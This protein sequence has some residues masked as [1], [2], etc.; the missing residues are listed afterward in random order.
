[1]VQNY[2]KIQMK[3]CP[4][5][6]EDL[7]RMKTKRVYYPHTATVMDGGYN[8]QK[9]SAMED[10]LV[11]RT[12]NR[13]FGDVVETKYF[14]VHLQ[15]ERLHHKMLKNSP[16]LFQVIL[17]AIVIVIV[18]VLAWV[19]TVIGTYIVFEIFIFVL[20]VLFIVSLM[21]TKSLAFYRKHKLFG[22]FDELN[23]RENYDF[24]HDVNNIKIDGLLTYRSSHPQFLPGLVLREYHKHSDDSDMLLVMI[25][26]SMTADDV[27]ALRYMYL[28]YIEPVAHILV[29]DEEHLKAYFK[30][31]YEYDKTA[32][33]NML[34]YIEELISTTEIK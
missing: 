27:N 17:L 16:F 9:Y 33:Y 5:C 19:S 34:Q 14:N 31:S 12:C 30:T 21:W 4:D 3:T 13:T 10:V 1:M 8:F 32:K 20:I 25:C 7:I 23:I 15:K 18:L 11:C 28:N 2:R 6:Q 22:S 29:L 26:R 24:K